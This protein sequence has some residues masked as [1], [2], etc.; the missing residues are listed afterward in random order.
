MTR[1]KILKTG[2]LVLIAITLQ[3]C[4]VIKP[5]EVGMRRTVGKLK[6]GVLHP[7]P[8]MFNPFVTKVIR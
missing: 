1:Q 4:A 8:H 5:G 7:G 6:N 2:V 3:N